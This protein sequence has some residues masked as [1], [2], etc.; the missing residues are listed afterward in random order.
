M[1]T[2]LERLSQAVNSHDAERM[3][4]LFAEDYA[5]PQPVHPRRGFGGRA[6][7]AKNWTAIFQA[8]PD[9]TA[10]VVRVGLQCS[11]GRAS[12]RVDL[13]GP[14]PEGVPR[15]SPADLRVSR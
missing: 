9:F 1:P 11:R 3:A 2:T 15:C 13:V 4:N 5:S 8:V 12:G 6:Q 10:E 7:V 14:R